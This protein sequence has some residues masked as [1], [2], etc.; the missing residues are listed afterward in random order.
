MVV[1][2]ATAMWFSSWICA[3]FLLPWLTA[4]LQAYQLNEAP[5]DMIIG[6]NLYILGSQSLTQLHRNLSFVNSISL[7]RF[8]GQAVRMVVDEDLFVVVVC[9]VSRSGDCRQFDAEG[10]EDVDASFRIGLSRPEGFVLTK[11]Y[12]NSVYTAA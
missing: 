3:L 4:P 12:S 11:V 2:T 10:L 8:D 1:H 5:K 7:L 9:S 6:E